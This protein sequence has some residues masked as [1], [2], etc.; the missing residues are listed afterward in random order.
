MW[1][2]NFQTQV[3]FFRAFALRP[4]NLLCD[5]TMTMTNFD[6]GKRYDQ[7]R[8]ALVYVVQEIW[9]SEAAIAVCKRGSGPHHIE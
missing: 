7:S 4:N 1:G 8:Y 3:L 9:K 5:R 6:D 2:D